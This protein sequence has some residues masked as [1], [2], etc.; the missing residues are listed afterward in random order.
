[1]TKGAKTRITERDIVQ[2]GGMGGL[3][4][5]LVKR[6]GNGDRV[7]DMRC[8]FA[9]RLLLQE[10]NAMHIAVRFNFEKGEDDGSDDGR[11]EGGEGGE[12]VEGVPGV[13][14]S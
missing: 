8:P 1:M 13:G 7:R 2:A 5:Q 4:T 10:L 12:G 3:I 11:P 9:F 14:A 6:C